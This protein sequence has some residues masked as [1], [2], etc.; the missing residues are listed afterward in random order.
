MGQGNSHNAFAA[1]GCLMSKPGPLDR[2]DQARTLERRLAR[3]HNRS[4]PYASL[5]HSTDGVPSRSWKADTAAAVLKGSTRLTVFITPLQAYV[6][7]PVDALVRMRLL[8]A[9]DV[10][11]LTALHVEARF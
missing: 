5:N 3:F 11:A 9:A 4:G 1:N 6:R 7:V 10:R 2:Q 8:E